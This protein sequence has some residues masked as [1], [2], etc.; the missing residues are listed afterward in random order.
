VNEGRS[1]LGPQERWA[2]VTA[3]PESKEHDRLVKLQNEPFARM[4]A[5]IYQMFATPAHTPEG[6]RAKV[7]VLLRCIMG[8]D[9]CHV[10]A[11]TDYPEQMARNLLIELIGGSPGEQLRG[12]FA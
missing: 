2:L 9:W 7:T 6:R 10:D 11:E 8:G 3:M 1:A 4:N 12:Q 5:L